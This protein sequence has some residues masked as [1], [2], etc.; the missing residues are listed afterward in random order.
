VSEPGL[1]IELILATQALAAKLNTGISQTI[2]RRDPKSSLN[3][4]R[5]K[6][7]VLTAITACGLSIG[8]ASAQDAPVK[9]AMVAN[10]C[11]LPKP[12]DPALLAQIKRMGEPGV[13]FVP[14]PPSTPEAAQADAEKKSR[15]WPELCHYRAANAALSAPP[16]VVFIGD[17]ITEGWTLA[18]P[19]LFSGGIVGRGIS[20]QTS[21]QMLAR[22]RADVIALNPKTVHIMAGTNDVAG[23]TGPTTERDFENNI[24]SM[25]DLARA[26]G[27][28]I[29]L[30]SIPPAANFWWA[31]GQS[32]ASQI[33][34]LNGWLRNFA[35]RNDLI[36][37]NYYDALATADGAF[38]PDLSN[39]GVHP[40][41]AGYA[42]MRSIAAHAIASE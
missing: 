19:D 20:G 41:S 36:Y 25:V 23:N 30:A 8:M 42:V 22:F 15:D 24:E 1:I 7:S 34:H 39:D 26:H 31:P 3:R 27:I 33:R 40:N 2:E 18:E 21:P 37:V 16:Q 13:G 28:R 29:M 6:L 14:P 17:S 35:R 5:T 12:L 9:T 32:P 10:P 11:P 38:R 4:Y